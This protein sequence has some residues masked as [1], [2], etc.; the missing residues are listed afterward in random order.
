MGFLERAR[1]AVGSGR[2]RTPQRHIRSRR[3]R[4][5]CSLNGEML[6][7]RLVLSAQGMSFFFSYSMFTPG[8]LTYALSGIGIVTDN[9]QV[10][11]APPGTYP[12]QTGSDF[13]ALENEFVSL[14]SKSG[15]TVADLSNLNSDQ[16][17]IGSGWSSVTSQ[18][19]WSAVSELANSVAGGTS[20]AQAQT[21]FNTLFSGSG[22]AQSVIDQTFSDLVQAIQDSHV[23]TTDLATVASDETAFANDMNSQSGGNLD[24][25]QYFDAGGF[26]YQGYGYG[27]GMPLIPFVG[28][29]LSNLGVLTDV[30][31]TNGGGPLNPTSQFYSDEQ[32]LQTEFDSLAEKSGL[33]VS[34]MSNLISDSQ[35]ILSLWE[36]GPPIDWAGLYSAIGE[37]ANAVASGASTTQAQSDF[38]ASLSPGVPS[39]VVDK[40]F[41]DIVQAVEDSH[42]TTADLSAV[43][44]DQATVQSDL[45]GTGVAYTFIGSIGG[46]GGTNTNTNTTSNSA[47]VT[48]PVV[49]IANTPSTVATSGDATPSVA[50]SAST[51]STVA[52]SGDA[53]P[54]AA[55]STSTASTIGVVTFDSKKKTDN[56]AAARVLVHTEVHRTKVIGRGQEARK[57]ILADD[58]FDAK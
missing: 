22:V 18:G 56:K 23:T 43:A 49:V 29:Y 31:P 4:R 7:N 52:T 21:D 3:P 45:A 46:M 55:V 1:L 32:T 35:A 53:T 50:V 28:Q 30:S 5:P 25:Q 36:N 33:T 9:V 19:L 10:Q 57:R 34:D 38:D 37:T 12:P 42:V 11:T 39:S 6:E 27:I 14:A 16:T 54:S 58:R 47:D 15:I 44:N 20:T 48:S 8:N 13:Q 41:D 51:P 40:A 24:N 2:D 17:A 26:S